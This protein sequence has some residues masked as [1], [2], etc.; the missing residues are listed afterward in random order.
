MNPRPLFEV[1]KGLGRAMPWYHD[2][3]DIS[4]PIRVLLGGY[5]AAAAPAASL[6]DPLPVFI[7]AVADPEFSPREIPLLVEPAHGDP[8][9]PATQAQSL[10]QQMASW[11]AAAATL[12]LIPHLHRNLRPALQSHL[13]DAFPETLLAAQ[14]AL[15][16]RATLPAHLLWHC[17]ILTLCQKHLGVSVPE[18]LIQAL[19]QRAF[20]GQREGPLH[21][22]GAGA[23]ETAAFLDLCALHAAYNAII[24]TADFDRFPPL[25]RLV[26]WHLAHTQPDHIT[27]DPWALAAFAG[28]DP[29]AS[30]AQQQLHD[31]TTHLANSPAPPSPVTLALLADALI[32]QEEASAA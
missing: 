9:A 24:F 5:A 10:P 29:S 1:P 15:A 21:P 17:W 20:A 12:R 32:T 27:T 19:W 3:M 23:L 13:K 11:L 28:L 18:M 14:K 4:G 26:D 22:V 31:T 6:K 25:Q 7:H 8:L 16:L 30:F 2:L